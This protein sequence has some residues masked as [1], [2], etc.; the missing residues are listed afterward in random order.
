MVGLTRAAV[1]VLGLVVGSAASSAPVPLDAYGFCELP[2]EGTR[3]YVT[4]VFP[5]PNVDTTSS[6]AD[7]F[8]NAFRTYL[9]TRYEL[10]DGN[11]QCFTLSSQAEAQQFRTQRIE[12]LHWDGWQDVVATQWTP[13]LNAGVA[14]R[15]S[16]P[17][18][19]DSQVPDVEIEPP[20]S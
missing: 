12:I 8:A 16:R 10:H 13:A 2:G 6:S 7:A 20:T 1:A 17:A 9:V 18:L 19:D 3:A 4:P 15:L 5:A 11:A 14:T